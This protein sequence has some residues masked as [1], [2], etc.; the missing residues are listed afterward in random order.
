MQGEL[1]LPTI[2]NV[3]VDAVVRHW[4]YLMEEGYGGD[5]SDRRSGNEAAQLE[6]Q[7]IMV[8][9]DRQRRTEEGHIWL[10]VQDDI[11]YADNG[12]VASTDLGW[13]QTAFE[14]LMGLFDRLVLKTNPAKTVGMVCHPCRAVGVRADKADTQRITGVGRSYKEI[15]RERVI[16]PK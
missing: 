2:F 4:E 13:L 7:T 12:M 16:F 15:Q 6:R 14:T 3:V 10:K 9:D 1:L 8:R 5:D 11:L